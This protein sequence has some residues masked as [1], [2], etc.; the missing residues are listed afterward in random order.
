MAIIAAPETLVTARAAPG[1]ARSS[2][3]APAP[4]PV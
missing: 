1:R 3:R 4:T 2:R